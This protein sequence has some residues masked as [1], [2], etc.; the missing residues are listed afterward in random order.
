MIYVLSALEPTAM[1][2][3]VTRLARLLKPGGLFFFRDYASGDMAQE[4][5]NARG[6]KN[7]R[8]EHTYARGEGT[9]AHYF[10]RDEVRSLFEDDG[11]LRHTQLTTV[12][13]AIENRKMAI[14]M[15]R[16][17]LQAKFLRQEPD[18]PTSR[19]SNAAQE[20]RDDDTSSFCGCLGC[21]FL[22]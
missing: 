16:I 11:L 7:K 9:L 5:F 12:E 3:A 13:R 15:Q 6:A 18:D 19:R 4:R 14:T 8:D 17:W 21:C 10:T 20:T 22:R 1:R 2:A